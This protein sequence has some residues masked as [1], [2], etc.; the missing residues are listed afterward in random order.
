MPAVRFLPDEVVSAAVSGETLLQAARRAGVPLASACGG[1]AACSTCRVL[2]IED[3]AGLEPPPE[4]EAAVLAPLGAEA[5]VRLGCRARVRG[6]VTV[7]RL[8]IY[9]NDEAVTTRWKAEPEPLGR[10]R[11]VGVLFADLR[12]F[13]AFSES[14]LPYDVVHVLNRFYALAEASLDRHAGRIATYLGDGFMALFGAEEAVGEPALRAVRAGLSLIDA[15]DG[16]KPY[17]VALHGRGLEVSVGV[18]FGPAVVGALGHGESRIVTAVGDVVNTAARIEQANRGFG[19]HLLVSE[20]VM[21]VAGEHLAASALP[22]V[23]LP[24]KSGRHVLYAVT[25]VRP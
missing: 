6:P 11:M 22:P 2:I 12:G 1:E 7:R 19:T 21:R 20:A 14:L 9:E 24:G 3:P 8:V 17:L 4:E 16:W 5:A 18:H 15:V 13:T 25:G 23:G 10:E